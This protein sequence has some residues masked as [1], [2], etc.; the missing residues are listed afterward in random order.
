MKKSLLSALLPLLCL[1]AFPALAQPTM[2]FGTNWSV[3]VTGQPLAGAPLR[4]VYDT[5]RLPNCR[6]PSWAITGYMMTNHGTVT[7][8]PVADASTVGNPAQALVNLTTGG[9]LEVW[10]QETDGNG[11]SAWDSNVGW[12]FHTKVLQNPTISFYEG[13]THSVYGTLQGGTTLMVDYDIDRLGQCR[14]YYLNYKAWGVSVHYRINGGAETT[15]P[16]TVSWGEWNAQYWMQAPAF[17]PL[18]AGPGT[19]ELWFSNEDRKGCQAWDS[20]YGQN[21]VFNFQ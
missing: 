11:C 17:I 15:L 3:S 10:F 6:G 13:W 1:V 18:P 19:L 12:N 9:E 8:F 7:S 21:Y 2:T 5:T 14:A 20:N 16:L 4:I